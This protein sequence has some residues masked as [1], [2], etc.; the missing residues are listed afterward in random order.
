MKNIKA[1][2]W[3]LFFSIFLIYSTNGQESEE[4][5]LDAHV[6]DKESGMPIPLTHVQIADFSFATITDENGWFRIIAPPG[7]Y[8]FYFS[9]LS[10]D[11]A[12]QL[13][14]IKSDTSIVIQMDKKLVTMEE[15]V[16]FADRIVN[17]TPEKYSHVSDYEVFND[18]P[19]L[20]GH[21]SKRLKSY[22]YLAGLSGNIIDTLAIG[23]SVT[24]DTDYKK[25][26]WIIRKDSVSQIIIQNK[27]ISLGKT[28]SAKEYSDSI[29]NVLLKWDEQLYFQDKFVGKKGLK[30]Y[31]RKGFSDSMYIFSDI[32]DSVLLYL[33]K[34]RRRDQWARRQGDILEYL[35]SEGNASR[36]VNPM[37]GSSGASSRGNSWGTLGSRYITAANQEP[38]IYGSGKFGAVYVDIPGIKN[39]T[40]PIFKFHG[41]LLLI[42]Y[43]NRS[44]N[45]YNKRGIMIHKVL[46]SYHIRG[47]AGGTLRKI[48]YPLVDE[49]NKEVYVWTQ[50]LDQVEIYQLNVETGQLTKRINMDSFKNV[51]KLRIENGKLYFLYSELHYPYATRLYTMVL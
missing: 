2:F 47:Q 31:Y 48:F 37:G 36:G 51:Q 44:I 35:A 42:D 8:N 10:Y 45:F 4:Y 39:V 33:L 41:M 17:L 13:I 43:Y 6:V 25:I 20:I 5:I 40:A 38:L 22:L 19:L 29:S 30:T 27:Q 12:H 24:L 34:H 11:L 26:P 16:I 3:G 28:I 49:V 50:K 23:E 46:I 1:V 32:T 15:V 7:S 21:P 14:T 18:K 9:H